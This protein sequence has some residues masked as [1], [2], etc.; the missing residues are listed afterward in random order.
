MD[1]GDVETPI[2]S[3]KERTSWMDGSEAEL[4]NDAIVTWGSLPVIGGEKVEN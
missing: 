3:S 2:D 4:P 1:G